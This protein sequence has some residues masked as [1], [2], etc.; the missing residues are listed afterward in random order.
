[1][2]TGYIYKER[3]KWRVRWY[4]LKTDGT[5]LRRFATLVNV[6]ENYPTK[7]SVRLLALKHLEPV[8]SGR[9]QPES[10][11]PLTEF[12]ENFYLP[13]VKQNLRPSTYKDYRNDIYER[14]LKDRLGNIKLRD[15]RTVNGQRLIAAV[16]K[17][18]PEIGHKTLLRIKS[19]ASGVFR[20]AR[21]EGLLDDN[22]PMRDVRLPP[23]V[24]RKKFIGETYTVPEIIK[25]LVVLGANELAAAVVAVAAFTGLRHSELRGL[26][27]GDY[28]EANQRL[29]VRRSM[30][31]TKMQP[32]KTESSEASVPVL[33]IL[34]MFIQ[35]HHHHLVGLPEEGDLGKT[36]QP[37][38][39]MFE[40]EKRR[41]SL[42]L[43]NLVRRTINPMLKVCTCGLRFDQHENAPHEFK[44]DPKVP[45][46]RGWHSF[47]RSLASNL[48]S[49]G[50]KPALIQ[51]ILRHADIHTTMMYYVEV[52]EKDVKA[53]LDELNA[54]M[55]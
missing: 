35:N 51:A 20:H 32:T 11:M 22:N 44:L 48:Y 18:F 50:V 5:R 36:L 40:G 37:T 15:F 6:D 21:T 12:I 14:H 4:E 2:Q 52:S 10:L 38:D 16:H 43:N 34:K 46:W 17:D 23:G 26:Q 24:R 29:H 54:L 7:T 25:M 28:D 53:A 42:N 39:W 45:Q 47:R 9:T 55:R 41:T 49:L 3:G 33:P 30:W 13:F 31:R 1:M 19:F 27:W 8:N